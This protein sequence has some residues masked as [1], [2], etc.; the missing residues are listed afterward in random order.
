MR[1]R[2]NKSQA[3]FSLVEGIVVVSI[4]TIV[5]GMSILGLANI[6]PSAKANAATSQVVSLLREAR[7]RAISHRCDIQI[8]FVGTNQLTVS[9]IWLAGAPPPPVTYS[10]EGNAQY[11]VFPGV[12]DTPMLFGNAAAVYFEGQAGGPAIMKFTS[13]GAFIDGG[14]SFVNGTVFLGINGNVG[15]ARAVTILGATGRVRQYH[16]D[17]AR[18]LE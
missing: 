11:L 16:W 13:T 9:E 15:T 4:I 1:H 18:W 17:G 14:N 8:Q 10:W 6:L 5:V 7:Q 2:C 3:G 12:P